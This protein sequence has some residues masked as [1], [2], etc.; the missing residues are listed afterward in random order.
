MNE[1]KLYIDTDV[2]N[3]Y[4]EQL[5]GCSTDVENSSNDTSNNF[6][7]LKMIN[8]YGDGIKKIER[9]LNE[10]DGTIIQYSKT[11]D[12][13]SYRYN[14]LENKGL[15]SVNDI[16][17]PNNFNLQGP[18]NSL[19]SFITTSLKKNDGTSVSDGKLDDSIKEIDEKTDIDKSNLKDMNNNEE[20]QEQEIDSKYSIEDKNINSMD[21]KKEQEQKELSDNYNISQASMNY[22]N[23]STL[24]GG[25]VGAA[26]IGGNNIATEKKEEEKEE[27]VIEKDD[28]QQNTDISEEENNPDKQ[29]EKDDE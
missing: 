4:S 27:E 16:K 21:N 25:S 12:E 5:K 13:F 10:V 6:S 14:D 1:D 29:E 7:K 24:Q 11:V 28:T 8:I 15:S 17:I 20:Q 22:M 19:S 2:M 18:V 3:I 9:G 26:S 23:N